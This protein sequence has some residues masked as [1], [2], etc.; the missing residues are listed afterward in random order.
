MIKYYC[1]K[2]KQEETKPHILKYKGKITMAFVDYPTYSYEFGRVDSYFLCDKC[3][4][5]FNEKFIKLSED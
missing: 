3:F 1:D 2:C 5:E 4:K